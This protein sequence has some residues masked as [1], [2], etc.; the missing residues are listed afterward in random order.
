MKNAA[1]FLII[2]LLLNAVSALAQTDTARS[3]K[4]FATDY[5]AFV[6]KT[7]EKFSDIPAVGIVVIKDDKPVFVRALRS[8]G[9]ELSGVMQRREQK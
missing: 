4:G 8:T 5:D 2:T 1:I 9:T 6:R 7:L 3:P